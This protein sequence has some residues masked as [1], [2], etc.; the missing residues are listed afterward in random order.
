MSH[1]TTDGFWEYMHEVYSKETIIRPEDRTLIG[2]MHTI[3]IVPGEPF[4][5]DERSR[6]MLDKAAVVAD[7]MA[8]NFAYNPP[9]KESFIY[10]PDTHWIKLFMTDNPRFE[11]ERG[12]IQ[13]DQRMTYVTQA[14]TTGYGMVTPATGMGS[15]YLAAFQDSDGEYFDGSNLYKIH[16]PANPP[17][18]RFWS[19]VVYDMDTRTMIQ[20]DQGK[21][22]GFGSVVDL[23]YI[24][25]KD[26]SYDFYV[27][28]EA[29]EGLES[30][31]VKTNE[32]DGF[33]LYFRTY[34]P[35]PEFF[36]KS[37]QL[38]DVEKIE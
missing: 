30:N 1:P 5:P 23:G 31:W 18:E 19:L 24:Q 37:W 35:T 8:R 22:P 29:P 20:N 14:V 3:G 6:E 38:P 11:D 17:A 33:F 28:P 10:Y 21:R 26:G 2:L 15:K 13:I 32:G 34:F 7:L 25:N 9:L 16:L 27:G 4:E 36:D 12:A